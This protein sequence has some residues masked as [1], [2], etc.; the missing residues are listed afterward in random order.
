MIHHPHF[1]GY[2]SLVNTATHSFPGVQ[3]ATLKGWRRVW[4]HTTHRTAAFLT[5]RPDPN[6]TLEGLIAAVPDADWH[7]LD[8]R[9]YA[10]DRH[11]VTPLITAT[12][13][14]SE[15]AV[16]AI[17]D[18]AHVAPSVEHPILL[19]YLDVVVQGY[20]HRFGEDGVARFFATTDGWNAPILNDRAA[21]RYPRAQTLTNSEIALV[22]HFI[23][24]SSK[25]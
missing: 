13:A 15:T 16:Y 19:S 23:A 24:A 6:T 8:A 5:V 10:Y 20:L 14:P 4:R 3:H 11:N 7:A 17:P 2:G 12:N 25:G 21:P 9:E 18:D 22:D 1:F